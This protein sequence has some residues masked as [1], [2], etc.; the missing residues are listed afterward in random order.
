[1]KKYF[2][3]EHHWVEVQGDAAT[4]GL[5]AYAVQELGDVTF[6]ELPEVE[7]VLAPGDVLCVVESAKAAV[8]VLSP[9]SGA[10]CEVNQRLDDEPALLNAA[11]ESDGWIC[12][13]REFDPEELTALMDEEE[14]EEFLAGPSDQ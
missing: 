4:L 9:L 11:P 5:T 8:E 12:R 2:S 10:V 6:V 7:S 1:M 3:E 13:L 14:Y